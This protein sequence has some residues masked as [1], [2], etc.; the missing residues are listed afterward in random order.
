MHEQLFHQLLPG[1][2]AEARDAR[3]RG[4]RVQLREV[5]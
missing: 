1:E 3:F 5:L 4:K 2:H